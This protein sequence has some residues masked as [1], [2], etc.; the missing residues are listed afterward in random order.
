MEL[1]ISKAYVD[2]STCSE[3]VHETMFLT[4]NS[5]DSDLQFPYHRFNVEKGMECIGLGKW[6]AK[7][8]M[9]SKNTHFIDQMKLLETSPMFCDDKP[10]ESNHR[11]VL[12][13]MG[14]V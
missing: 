9:M 12:F 1:K 4:A 10:R 5:T 11:I 7:V 13:D 8:R 3:P 6:K 2:M 14:G